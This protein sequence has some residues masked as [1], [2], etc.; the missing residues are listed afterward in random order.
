MNSYTIRNDFHNTSVTIR[1]EGLSHLHGEVVISPNRRQLARM[2]KAL[3]GIKGCQCSGDDGK[4]GNSFTDDGKRIVVDTSV[5][6]CGQF[7][8]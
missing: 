2:K 7:S 5:L 8:R 3:C 4:R 1:C 6:Y